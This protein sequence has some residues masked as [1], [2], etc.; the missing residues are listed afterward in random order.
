M[1]WGGVIGK[2]LDMSDAARMKRADMRISAPESESMARMADM[3]GSYNKARK[4]R[5]APALDLMLPFGKMPE[6]YLRKKAYGQDTD[7]MDRLGAI[8]GLL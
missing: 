1:S 4:E 8:L 7:Y 3:A 6:D 5:L 2:L